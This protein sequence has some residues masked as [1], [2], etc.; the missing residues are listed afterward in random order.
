MNA[1]TATL[2]TRKG[3]DGLNA[4]FAALLKAHEFDDLE[5]Q[6]FSL[7][8]GAD[9][10]IVALCQAIP[11]SACQFPEDLWDDL[12]REQILTDRRGTPIG[13]IG[14]DVTGHWEGPGPGFEVCYYAKSVDDGFA[15]ADQTEESLREEAQHPT[16][17]QGSAFKV[18]G[19]GPI[20][21]LDAIY[22][23]L[24]SDRI[25]DWYPGD[26]RRGSGQ[27]MPVGFE[28]HFLAMWF[29]H[30]RLR[31]ALV[32]DLTQFGLIRPMPILFGSHDF[33]GPADMDGAMIC[34]TINR[35]ILEPDVFEVLQARESAKA[36]EARQQL[37]EEEL[38]ELIEGYTVIELLR[39][40]GKRSAAMRYGNMLDSV[41]AMKT[42]SF[43]VDDIKPVATL[44]PPEFKAAMKRL[45]LARRR[46]WLEAG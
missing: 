40:Q 27:P 8:K 11:L 12:V 39:D 6:L 2:S 1:L 32:R 42:S 38:A 26:P 15:F 46:L 5:R 17:W 9:W 29:L 18:D 25:A 13:A 37:A 14:F 19:L 28:G 43:E 22:Q 36:L 3:Y 45:Y 10:P 23:T 34:Q 31:Q 41:I 30:L 35:L 4:H 33:I 16:R 21:G 44:S 7:M 24:L 20:T